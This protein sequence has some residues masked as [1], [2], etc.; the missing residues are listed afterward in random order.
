MHIKRFG[1]PAAL[2]VSA[3]LAL[4]ACTTP[5]VDGGNVVVTETDTVDVTEGA[6]GT[7]G[8]ATDGNIKTVSIGRDAPFFSYNNMVP[9]GNHTANSDILQFTT[10]NFYYFD[11][12]MNLVNNTDFGTIT[13][14]NED[15]FTVEMHINDGVVWS[16]GTPVDAADLMLMW[17]AQDDKFD[18]VASDE[19]ETDEDGNPIVAQDEVFF[20]SSNTVMTEHVLETPTISEDGKTLT[21]VIDQPPSDWLMSLGMPPVSAHTVGRLALGIDD[22]QEAKD[23]VVNAFV[24]HDNAALAPISRTW[25]DD[26]F[27]NSM[28]S[29]PGLA[30]S[31]GPYVMSEFEEGQYMVLERNPLYT[32][33]PRPNIDQVIFRWN[34]D[35]LAQIQALQNGQMDI[36]APMASVDTLAALEG[37]PGITHVPFDDSAWEHIDLTYNNG[38][39]FDPA[40]YGGNA[41]TARLVRQAFLLTVPR[42]QIVDTLIQPLDPEAQARNSFMFVPGTAEY[43]R[44]VAENG[45]DFYGDGANV[46]EA[47]A[48]LEQAG[49][50]TP[51]D[52]RLLFNGNLPR[53]VNQAQMMQATAEQAGF[54][55]IL[56]GDP[57][58]SSRLGDGTYD[59]AL[60][61]WVS[62]NP[63]LLNSRSTYETGQFNNHQGVS[64][65]AIDECWQTIAHTTD[66]EEETQ[67]GIV[68]DQQLFEDGASL[69]L[70]QH[71]GILAHTERLTGVVPM[72]IGPQWMWNFWEWDLAS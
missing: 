55:I 37:L 32:W 50:Q 62:T 31:T 18:T 33:G 60:F 3:A 9:N 12:Q 34:N 59:A 57:T 28:P 10:S 19:V 58:W 7:A 56:D 26:F 44:A 24:N 38:G 21:M 65:P 71:P 25:N 70:F 41:E 67:C 69:P 40:T 13:V 52:V 51:I 39:P 72:P 2:A 27:F 35:P 61:A 45:W 47:R 36:I 20:T 14:V 17:G 29:D 5:A 4:S 6:P 8:G 23:A 30:L 42:Q 1:V 48:L 46:E 63:Y 49:V 66:S 53:R 68:I 16:D 54:N 22:P 15:P 43:E 64:L 11:D